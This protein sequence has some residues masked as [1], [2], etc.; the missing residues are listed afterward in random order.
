MFCEYCSQPA[1][2]SGRM[3]FL[4][5]VG[6]MPMVKVGGWKANGKEKGGKVPSWLFRP[7]HQT[8]IKPFQATI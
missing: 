7:A 2:S 3:A 1:E 5:A 6:F 8:W 4:I